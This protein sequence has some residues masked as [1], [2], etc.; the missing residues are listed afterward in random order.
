MSEHEV[1]SDGDHASATVAALLVSHDG[2]RWLPTVLTGLTAQTRRPD[3]VVGVDTGSRDESV[4][5]VEPVVDQLVREKLNT[6]FPQA[7]RAGLAAADASVGRT[8]WVWILHDDSTPAPDAL[9]ALLA[10][11]AVAPDADILGPKL[12]EWPSL[13]RLLELGVSISATGRRETGLERG[14]YDQGQHDDVRKV[15]AVNTA[16]ML[17]RRAVLDELG[18]FD[19]RL[20]IFGNDLDFG[21]RAARAGHTTLIVP[22]SVVFHAEAAH[23][24]VR[25]TSLTGRHTHLAERT[26]ALYTLLVNCQASM[27]PVQAVRLF[28]GSLL[29]VLGFLVVRS[30]GEAIDE[31]AAVLSVYSR[32]GVLLRARRARTVLAAND[33]QVRGLLAPWWLPYRHGLDLVSDLAAAAT[34]QASDVAERRRAAK[35]AERGET[36]QVHTAEDELEEDSGLLVRFL[37]NPVAMVLA[38]FLL[39]TLIAAHDALG[40]GSLTAPGLSPVPG[41]VADWW[42]LHTQA[43]HPIAQG[44]DA[45]APAYLLPFVL[46]GT[47]LLGHAGAVVALV[48]LLAAPMATWGAWR[49]LRVLGHLA[50]PRGASPWLLAWGSLTY[51]LVPLA[52]GA[53]AQGRFGTLV[54][55]ATLPWLVHTA[56]GFG[57]PT[58]DRRWRAAWRTGLLLALVTAFT[59]VAW[60]FA[61]VLVVGLLG[62]GLRIAPALVRDRSIWGPMV[63][64]VAVVPV[65]LLPWFLPSLAH[66]GALLL[67]AGRLPGPLTEPVDLLAGQLAGVAAPALAGLLLLVVAALALVPAESRRTALVPWSVLAVAT[68]MLLLVSRLTVHLP[69][70]STRPASGFLT[71]TTAGALVVAVALAA[72]RLWPRAGQPVWLRG[73]VG[74]VLVLVTL[75]PALGLGWALLSGDNRLVED[76]DS[77]IPAYMVQA[78]EAGDQHGILVLRGSVADGLT[79][80]VWRGD[81]ITLGEDEIR[82]YAEPDATL[83]DEIRSLVSDPS[84]SVVEQLATAGIEY[85]VLPAPADGDVAAQ[86]DATTGLAQASAED[87]DT[88]AWHLTAAPTATGIAGHGSW[89]R[90]VLVGLQ[91]LAVVAVA[92]LCAPTRKESR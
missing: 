71:V 74:G 63:T 28:F 79:Y 7:V 72:E 31:L 14:E 5:L 10:A 24:G 30:P 70:S 84:K 34:N 85:V 75:V 49:L 33:P 2:A 12:R 42:R 26:G 22:Q 29:R 47:L 54:A 50:D 27:L 59:P 53:W 69:T 56:L 78:A 4:A 90:W 64:T 73:T 89:F 19:N 55:A 21:W 57:D 80:D 40:S 86:L 68:V 32:P 43:W 37:T 13:K 1:S 77:G 87:P 44:T 51:G 9:E 61:V 66:P 23:R 83:T 48:F 11:A 17:V 6:T 25:K 52:S 41:G 46:A 35:L 81:G 88:R 3:H 76:A 38:G 15:L 16:G 20:P 91:L 58:A 82:A 62:V 92:V 8:E 36:V 39:L 18:G 65:L 60:V 45:P 67:E